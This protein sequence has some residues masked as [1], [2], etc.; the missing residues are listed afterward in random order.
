LHRLLLN[1]PPELQ[2]DHIN[3]DGL[4]NRRSNLRLATGSQNQGNSRKRR[5]GVTSQYRGVSWN[6]RAGKWQALLRREGKLQYLGYF[7][8]EEA[9]ARAYDAAALEQWGSFAR[10]NFPERA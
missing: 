5:D 7:S 3:G 8:D 2:V 6:K 4:D 10:L 1:A 9:A